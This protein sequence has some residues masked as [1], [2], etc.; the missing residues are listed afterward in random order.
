MLFKTLDTAQRKVTS[1][2]KHEY[3]L[4]DTVGF[5]SDLPHTLVDAFKATL[6]EVVGADLILEVVD[7]SFEDSA[8][9]IETTGQVLSE[10]GAG[11]R[12][13]VMVYNKID[14]AQ[15]DLMPSVPGECV[16]V[17]AK[18]GD[19]IDE[20]CAMITEKL[21]SDNVNCKLMIPF[22]RGDIVSFVREKGIVSDV[23]YNEKGT[24]ITAELTKE[25]LSRV[26]EY[27]TD[28]K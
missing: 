2:G 21:F 17:S 13:L 26:K 7:A 20:L 3:I 9:H 18:R 12:P 15:Y 22:R 10:I 1:D 28:Q 11:G 5:V 14:I 6:E 23:E 24:L 19:N 8:F 4:I 16:F 25:D 27:V